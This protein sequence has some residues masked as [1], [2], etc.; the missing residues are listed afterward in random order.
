MVDKRKYLR[1]A[2]NASVSI[3]HDSLGTIE[4]TTADISD[5]GLFVHTDGCP[6][7]AVGDEVKVQVCEIADAPVL[8]AV[9]VRLTT[10]GAGLRFLDDDETSAVQ[11]VS[12]AAR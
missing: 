9:V 10:E 12:H 7:F 4:L 5:G 3:M 1:T 11:V 8:R 2:I 6:Q